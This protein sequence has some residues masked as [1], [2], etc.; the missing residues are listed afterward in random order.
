MEADRPSVIVVPGIGT[1]PVSKWS[2]HTDRHHWL[3]EVGPTKGTVLVW[4]HGLSVERRFSL[5][6]LE[7]SA[8]RLLDAII[9]EWAPQKRPP[10]PILFISHSFGGVI[11]KQ[12]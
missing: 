3:H 1:L 10:R 4:E 5:E 8:F 2:P 12:V 7:I 6:V 11:V 9:T